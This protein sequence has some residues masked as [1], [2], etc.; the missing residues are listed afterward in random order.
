[1][2]N[3]MHRIYLYI[4]DIQNKLR[5]YDF[6]LQHT[7]T[8]VNAQKFCLFL[9]QCIYTCIQLFCTS[10]TYLLNLH[11]S[12]ISNAVHLIMKKSQVLI[13]CIKGLSSFYYFLFFLCSK[14]LDFMV[15][16]QNLNLLNTSTCSASFSLNVYFLLS[17]K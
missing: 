2:P 10:V 4:V 17:I 5:C 6:N 13:T 14:I 7:C 3:Y 1:M 9:V 11:T 8:G 15:Q 12:N 16:S